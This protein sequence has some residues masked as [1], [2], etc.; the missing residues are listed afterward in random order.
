MSLITVIGRG[1]SG[2][3]AISH[4][5]YA[6]GVFMGKLLNRS[7][8]KMPPQEMY[9]ACKVIAKRI[10]WD[11]GLSWDFSDLHTGEIDAEWDRLVESYL[12]DVMND[13]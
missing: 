2:T 1:H 6:S 13:K 11:G 7:G 8:D 3:R 5:L 12:A 10:K 4:T 9:D